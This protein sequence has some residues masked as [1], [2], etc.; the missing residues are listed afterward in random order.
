MEKALR[1]ILEVYRQVRQFGSA[2]IDAA[3]M[4]AKKHRVSQQ[5]V[6]SS[7]TRDVGI[8]G[9]TELD[10]LLEPENTTELRTLLVQRFPAY[11]KD[12]NDIFKAFDDSGEPTDSA[13]KKIETL[14]ED[15]RKNLLNELII[16]VFK[17]KFIEW[18][19]RSDIPSDMREQIQEWLEMIRR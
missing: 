2:R 19:T 7:C 17:D 13:S 5:T 12:I 9:A 1:H 3:K 16:K 8:Q 6:M 10:Y 14:F 4:V 11:Q 15:E 18:E